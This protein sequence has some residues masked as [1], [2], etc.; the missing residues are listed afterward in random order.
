MSVTAVI[1]LNYL[2]TRPRKFVDNF[3]NGRLDEDRVT[4][5]GTIVTHP[6]DKRGYA[7]E[8]PG[9]GCDKRFPYSGR[10]VGRCHLNSEIR[11]F[12]KRPDQAGHCAKKTQKR[13]DLRDYAQHCQPLF[14]SAK[15]SAS[16][17]RRMIHAFNNRTVAARQTLRLLNRPF[18]GLLDLFNDFGKSRRAG[19][20]LRWLA[21]DYRAITLPSVIGHILFRQ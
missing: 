12:D 17:I 4:V 21:F 2:Q 10:E 3:Q 9:G 15:L 6:G 18:R 13:L 7:D 5:G 14:P 11:N 8:K 1:H 16:R 20:T 19:R